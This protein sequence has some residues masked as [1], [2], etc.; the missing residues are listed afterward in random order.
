MPAPDSLLAQ[1]Q[2]EQQTHSELDTRQQTH[3]G[4]Q[5]VA[6]IASQMTDLN[7][8]G[9]GR[10]TYLQLKLDR[11]VAKAVFSCQG[12][13]SFRCSSSSFSPRVESFFG[14]CTFFFVVIFHFLTH[15]LAR[16]SLPFLYP[17][18]SLSISLYPYASYRNFCLSFI[19]HSVPS[20][21]PCQT[22][23]GFQPCAAFD[24][25]L[26]SLIICLSDIHWLATVRSTGHGS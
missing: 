3:G 19:R 18:L 15:S 13:L 24:M 21:L 1:A 5:S 20:T 16:S 12:L 6:G 4:M 17:L 8:V 9:E 23:T 26:R 25:S 2:A 22:F 11:S 14:A 10:N 7:K